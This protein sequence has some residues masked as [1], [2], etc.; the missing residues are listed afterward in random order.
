MADVVQEIETRSGHTA[1]VAIGC[2]RRGEIK[3]IRVVQWDDDEA[4]YDGFR[5]A[6]FTAR[7]ACQPGLLPNSSDQHPDHWDR[8]Q[9]LVGEVRAVAAG[10]D[11]LKKDDKP[12]TKV[13]GWVYRN[14]DNG[15]SQTNMLQRLYF[16]LM[17]LGPEDSNRVKHYKLFLTIEAKTGT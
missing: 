16:E 1:R 4:L 14:R 3:H 10:E 11:E 15:G 9:Y 7:E 2:A 12:D 17:D 8:V 5:F 13:E 6:L